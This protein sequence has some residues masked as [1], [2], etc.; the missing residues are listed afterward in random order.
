MKCKKND[1][2]AHAC[3]TSSGYHHHPNTALLGDS[4]QNG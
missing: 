2:K 3:R 1:V 4:V